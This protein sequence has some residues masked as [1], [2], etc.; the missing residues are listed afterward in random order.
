MVRHGMGATSD[1]MPNK[2][3]TIHCGL[4]SKGYKIE[5]DQW[6]VMCRTKLDWH[7]GKQEM[8]RWKLFEDPKSSRKG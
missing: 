3:K 5:P 8:E 6:A 2:Y 7:T 4:K 1:A